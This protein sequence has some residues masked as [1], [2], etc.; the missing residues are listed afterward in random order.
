VM[1]VLSPVLARSFVQG[2]AVLQ[3]R[4][5]TSLHLMSLLALPLLV[6]GAMVGWR[7]LPA[8]PGFAEYGRGG[9]ALSILAPSAALILLGTIVQN[10]LIAGHRQSR[11][12]GI[13]A[14]GA[15][16]NVALNVLL[17]PDFGLYAAAG[18]TLATEAAVLALSTWEVR[19]LGVHWPLASLVRAARATLVLAFVVA[20]T[21]WLP[22]LVQVAGATLAYGVALLPT[23]S[24]RWPDLG[25]LLGGDGDEVVDVVLEP[26]PPGTPEGAE[27]LEQRSVRAVRDRL[28]GTRGVRFHSDA[29]VPPGVLLGARLAACLDVEVVGTGARGGGLRARTSRRYLVDPPGPTL[30]PS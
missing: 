1:A 11:L 7:V 24:F 12:L 26:A 10:V 14:I 16:L 5:A 6:G 28:R 9:V 4:F 21:Y 29:P 22:A 19:R 13:A 18:A 27:P 3:R 25:G 17:I 8:L 20:L 30:T 15:L 23:G 2:H